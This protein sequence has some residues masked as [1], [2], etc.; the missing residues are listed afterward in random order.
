MI[1]LLS[2]LVTALVMVILFLLYYTARRPQLQTRQHL[3][4]MIAEAEAQRQAEKQQKTKVVPVGGKSVDD[5]HYM[6]E[7]SFKERVIRPL[8][9][10]VENWLMKFAPREM[11][12]MLENMLLHLGM[13]EKWS[14]NRLAA[15]WVL[16]VA[17]GALLA[18][19][20]ISALSPLQVP[21]QIAILVLGVVLGAVVPFLLLQSAIQQRKATIRR[22]LP[23][24]LDFLC[25]SVQ[26]GLSFDGAVA[27][28][29]HRM[30]G[31]LTEE[32][33]RMLRDMGLG[34]DRQR[35]LTQLAKRCDLEEMYLFTASV[36]QAEHLGTSMSRTLK[37]QADNMRDRHRQAV[38]AMALK[39]PVKI[40]FPMVL[41]IFP[42]IFVMVVF[43]SAL[44]LLKS[45]NQ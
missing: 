7:Q 12:T 34:M 27:K 35:T 37:I 26:A 45:L 31:P 40:I 30:K 10:S 25:V 11:R 5:Y 3:E 44:T 18:L 1:I 33:R 21:Q 9:I 29:V 28:I 8:V 6:R 2:A 36:I 23:E 32:F 4:R 13:Q 16:C 19:L 38:R 24:F 15:G 17:V 20:S 39:A 22:Q 42:A 14:I 41:F 43:P